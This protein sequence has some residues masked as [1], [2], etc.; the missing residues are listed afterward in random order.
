MKKCIAIALLALILTSCTSNDYTQDITRKYKEAPGFCIEAKIEAEFDD[1][2]DNYTVLYN[3]QKGND[4]SVKVLQPEE[5]AGIEATI[6][7]ESAIFKFQDT[8]LETG[9]DLES[10]AP[11]NVLHK[12]VQIWSFKEAVQ[13]GSEG[14]NTILV[15][16]DGDYQ[17][18]T[19][20]GENYLP[21]YAEVMY[22]SRL[23]M[24]IYFIKCEG[25]VNAD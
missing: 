13:V 15:F 7:G 10:V 20:F 23:K 6:D 9:I 16:D 21:I 11:I 8:I 3:Y 5:I 1:R 22:N 18:R 4:A 24:K 14:D 12:L 2:T 17:Y 25:I 19:A